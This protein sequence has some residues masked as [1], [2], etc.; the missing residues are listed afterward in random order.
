MTEAAVDV[1]LVLIYVLLA[2]VLT[3][4]VVSMVHAFKVRGEVDSARNGVPAKTIMWSTAAFFVV[5]L[6]L[7]YALGATDVLQVNGKVYRQEEW[8]K[9]TDMFINTAITLGV[10]AAVLMVLGVGGL[11]RRLFKSKSIGKHEKV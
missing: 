4:V 7:T 6:V 11:N 5:M 10:V 3:A 1:F 8:L 9:V 2:A